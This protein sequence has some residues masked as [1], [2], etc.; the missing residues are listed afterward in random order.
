MA[1]DEVVIDAACSIQDASGF[2][3]YDCELYVNGELGARAT[4]NVLSPDDEY[5]KRIL[6]E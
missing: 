5:L 4:L 6:D 1:G 2:G 3:V